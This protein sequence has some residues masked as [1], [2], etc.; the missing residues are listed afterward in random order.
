MATF[1]QEKLMTLISTETDKQ[2]LVLNN[3][4][5]FITSLLS[6]INLFFDK[7]LSMSYLSLIELIIETS[8]V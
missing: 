6:S 3:K 4:V 2:S 8:S 1:Q 5:N 7:K